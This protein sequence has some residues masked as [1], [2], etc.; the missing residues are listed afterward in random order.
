MSVKKIENQ[1]MLSILIPVFNYNVLPLVQNLKEQLEK[2]DFL[3]EIIVLD[4]ASTLF[5]EENHQLNE[6][7]NVVYEV[8]ENNIGRSK[9]RNLLTKK[10]KY[11]WLLFLDSDVM[12]AS[13]SFLNNYLPFLNEEIK[14]V[15]G[16]ILYQEQKPDRDKLLR[17]TYGREREALSAVAR[18]SNPYLS[19]L[20][21]N[22]LVHKNVLSKVSFNE[23]I[24]NLRHED[25][26]FSYNLKCSRIPIIHVNNPVY[27]FG[28]DNF[29]NAMRKE[30][31]AISAL[32][33]LLDLKLLPY[34]YVRISRILSW[35]KR[36]NLVKFLAYLHTKTEKSCIKNLASDSPTLLIFDFFRLTYL[37]KLYANSHV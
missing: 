23:S 18:T 32:K 19:F 13:V 5:K 21:L 37:C 1:I 20:T 7:K 25:T 26:L 3:Y 17:W 31:E 14:I 12:P 29:E 34:D 35:I 4:D 16:G 11:N 2:L 6:E 30:K 33:N 28:L 22:F 8:L 24:P 10:A 36:L 27:H 15:Y 9:I